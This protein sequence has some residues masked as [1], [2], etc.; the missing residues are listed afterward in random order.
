MKKLIRKSDQQEVVSQFKVAR[1]FASR[2]KGLMG[3]KTLDHGLLFPRCNSVHMWFMSIPI[4]VV[5]LKAM[6]S[7]WVIT[8]VRENIQPWKVLPVFDA[9]AHDTLEL[10]AG[11]VQKTK[12]KAGDILCTA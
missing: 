11:Q 1:S 12:L 10:P 2:L 6:K 5:F 4:D 9:T 8:S 7:E 3:S